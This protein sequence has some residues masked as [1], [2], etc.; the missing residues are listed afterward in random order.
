VLE[1]YYIIGYN[2]DAK[3]MTVQQ[4]IGKYQEMN[5]GNGKEKGLSIH[6]KKGK[7]TPVEYKRVETAVFDKISI[8]RKQS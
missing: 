7:I 4:A 5:K 2:I 1:L 6:D 3:D 8:H